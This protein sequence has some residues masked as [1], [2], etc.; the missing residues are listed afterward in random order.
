MPA[1][2][3]T[4]Q[5]LG[6]AATNFQLPDVSKE[7]A[8]VSLESAHGKP[9]LI[10]FICNHCPYVIY[11]IEALVAMANQAY[12][13]GFFVAAISSNDVEKYPQDSPE[14]MS[15]FAQQYG[16]KFPY[17]Y[18]QSQAVAK[19]YEAACTPDFYVYDDDHKLVYRGQFDASRP[20][21]NHALTGADLAAGQLAA[22]NGSAPPSQQTPSIGCTIKWRTDT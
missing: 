22:K 15:E 12:Q 18:D 19:A 21:N 3:S 7:G 6:S 11:M 9:V 13:D 5:A 17:L 20:G 8:L 14:K 10:M 16:F 1:V 2:E 4:M